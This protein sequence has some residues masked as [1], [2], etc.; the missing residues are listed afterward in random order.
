MKETDAQNPIDAEFYLD[1]ELLTALL[2]RKGK[3]KIYID[4]LAL[5]LFSSKIN[6]THSFPESLSR[7]KSLENSTRLITFYPLQISINQH[8]DHEAWYENKGIL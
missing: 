5:V 4:G 7:V 1:L 2:S 8:D 6:M 3:I